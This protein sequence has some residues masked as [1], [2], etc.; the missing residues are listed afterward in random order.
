MRLHIRRTRI[1]DLPEGQR[2]AAVRA[3]LAA[4]MPVRHR[5]DIATT[6]F[7]DRNGH[8]HPAYSVLS[9]GTDPQDAADRALSLIA[10]RFSPTVMPTVTTVRCDMG[11]MNP[12]DTCLTPAS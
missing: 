7:T 5:Y 12:D 1:A 2:S 10:L 4:H 8:E 3:T 9:Y 6:T 11:C